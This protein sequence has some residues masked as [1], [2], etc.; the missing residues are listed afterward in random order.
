VDRAYLGRAPRFHADRDEF[1]IAANNAGDR[2]TVGGWLALRPEFSTQARMPPTAFLAPRGVRR[3][4]PV[5]TAGL[6]LAIDTR[7]RV[8]SRRADGTRTGLDPHGPSEL[9]SAYLDAIARLERLTMPHPDQ[10]TSAMPRA[11]VLAEGSERDPEA[12]PARSVRRATARRAS[13]RR[14]T[15]RSRQGDT[16]ASI[17]DFLAQHPGSTAGDLAKGLNL[18]PGSVSARLTQLAKAGEIERASHGYRT[19]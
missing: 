18:D 13:N 16:E 19:K 5:L 4:L 3:G 11:E 12:A 15:A 6:V 10:Q 9:R 17:L 14:A 2:S 1:G 8:N 7:R